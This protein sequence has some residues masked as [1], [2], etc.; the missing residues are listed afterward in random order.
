MGHLEPCLETATPHEVGIMG[1]VVAPSQHIANAIANNVR[2]GCLHNSYPGQLATAGNFAI[3]LTPHE[4]PAGPVFKFS[5]YHLIP[6]DDP[7]DFPIEIKFAGVSAS[8]KIDVDPTYLPVIDIPLMK[9]SAHLSAA[10]QVK[11]TKPSKLLIFLS[12][13]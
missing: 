5:V 11:N 2:V 3:P 8:N 6:L 12:F 7:S 1:E 4:Q 9:P 10:S 13:K